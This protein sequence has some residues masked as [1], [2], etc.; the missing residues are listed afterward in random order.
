MNKGNAMSNGR[1]S[2]VSSYNTDK[3]P[4]LVERLTQ[5]ELYYKDI[6]DILEIKNIKNIKKEDYNIVSRIMSNLSN[7]YL[8][9][10]DDSG[11]YGILTNAKMDKYEQEKLD[12][13]LIQKLKTEAR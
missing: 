12:H 13:V 8:I 10:S 7:Y 11:I 1:L 6:M 2:V 3:I 5:G 9:Y 4:E